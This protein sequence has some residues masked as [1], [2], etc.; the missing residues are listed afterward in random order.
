MFV[1]IFKKN[2]TSFHLTKKV[3]VD[4]FWNFILFI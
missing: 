3:W 2:V 1:I 4:F